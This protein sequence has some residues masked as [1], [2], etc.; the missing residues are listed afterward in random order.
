MLC[1][2]RIS[3]SAKKYEIQEATATFVLLWRRLSCAIFFFFF[4]S[5]YGKSGGGRRRSA[6]A[7][8]FNDSGKTSSSIWETKGSRR[9]AV[10]TR[11]KRTS[12]LLSFPEKSRTKEKRSDTKEA[13]GLAAKSRYKGAEKKHL[14]RRF[15]SFSWGKRR[16]QR[17]KSGSCFF[18]FPASGASFSFPRLFFPELIKG[19]WCA[20]K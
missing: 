9:R 15:F 13:N 16:S 1:L 4:C 17:R 5:F 14:F 7:T 10:N 3:A 11:R 12:C 19:A 2:K 20:G 8:S 6:E 18:Q